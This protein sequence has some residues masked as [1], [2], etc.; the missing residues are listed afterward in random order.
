MSLVACRMD[1]DLLRRFDFVFLLMLEP[2]PELVLVLLVVMVGL[3][4]FWYFATLFN[5]VID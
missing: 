3:A 1:P 4:L 5:L 2:E